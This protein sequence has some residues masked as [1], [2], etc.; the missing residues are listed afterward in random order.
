M[1]QKGEGG[2]VAA[3]LAPLKN[4]HSRENEAALHRQNAVAQAQPTA[5]P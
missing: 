2:A 4:G 5:V 1:K 3:T